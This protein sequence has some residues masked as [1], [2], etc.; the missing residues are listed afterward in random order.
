MVCPKR[1][2]GHLVLLASLFLLCAGAHVQAETPMDRAWEKL[3]K[4]FKKLKDG[5]QEPKDSQK[6]TYQAL[7]E[8]MLAESARIREMSPQMTKTLPPDQQAAFLEEFK[9]EMDEFAGHLNALKAAVDGSQWETA[10]QEMSALGSTKKPAHKKFRV[11][12]Y[13]GP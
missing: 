2:P 8:T 9:K 3:E 7:V 4:A 13:K 5:L 11:E 10:R 6:T 12:N 1:F